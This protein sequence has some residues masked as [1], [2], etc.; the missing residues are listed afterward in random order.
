M[1]QSRSRPVNRKRLLGLVL[2]TMLLGVPAAPAMAGLAR[3]RPVAADR[4]PSV[5][6]K[7]RGDHSLEATRELAGRHGLTVLR[8]L[9]A[10]SWVELGVVGRDPRD[11]LAALRA[12]PA[13]AAVDA[14][15]PGERLEP[16]LRPRDPAWDV[17]FQ[18]GLSFAW[19]YTLTNFPAAWDSSRGGAGAPVA[20]I[21]SEFDTEHPDLKDKFLT[22]Y[23]ADSGHPAYRTSNVRASSVPELHG[24]HVAGL[25]GAAT[26]NGIGVSGASFDSPI[27]PVKV[28]TAFSPGGRVDAKFVADVSEAMTWVAGRGA[29]VVNLSLGTPRFHQPMQDAVNLLRGRGIVVVASAG[30]EQDTSERGVPNYPAAL[31]GVIAVAATDPGDRATPFST[32]GDFVDLAAPGSSI[33]STWDTRAPSSLGVAGYESLSGTSMSAPIVAGLA[34]LVRARRPDLTPEEVELVLAQSARDLGVPGKDPVYGF[35]RI[36]AAGALSAAAA[37][38]RPQPVQVQE[39]PA[40]APSAPVAR[41]QKVLS[42][43]ALRTPSRVR[44]NRTIRVRG[45]LRPANPAARLRLQRL[46]GR[47]WTTIASTRTRSGRFLFRFR[48]R[49]RG[50]LRLRVLV[51]GDASRQRA[52]SRVV[53]VRVR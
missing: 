32:N 30:N 39:A 53:R 37:Y 14:G 31:Q 41:P 10:I 38:Q 15:A 13:V 9:E 33:V 49:P 24:S 6:V 28:S 45:Q 3:E 1:E 5:L 18:G 50:T 43:L 23:N 51:L 46:R 21:D 27:I 47:R 36:D 4:P 19:H 40:P 42:R 34:G 26:D 35:G 17:T 25:V 22:G 8:D 29:G 48:A 52:A 16:A 20:V 11:A 2:A 12:D 44:P 7:L